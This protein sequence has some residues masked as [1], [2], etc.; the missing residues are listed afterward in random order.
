VER[1]IGDG[2][3]D[4]LVSHYAPPEAPVVSGG[5]PWE[6][7]P[8]VS[9]AAATSRRHLGAVVE[10]VRPRLV[11]HGHW[12]QHHISEMRSLADP[13]PAWLIIGLSEDESRWGNL[14]VLKPAR[15]VANVRDAISVVG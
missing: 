12:H 6:I 1:C 5:L 3:A 14:A 4:V 8:K 11:I 9:A 2:P 13:K 7:P 10:A 15:L